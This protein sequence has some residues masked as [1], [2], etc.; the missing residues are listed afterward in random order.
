MKKRAFTLVEMLFGIFILALGV[1]SISALFAVG[2]TQQKRSAEAIE[3]PM[4]ARH[5]ADVLRGKLQ[6]EDFGA[7]QSRVG[8]GGSI[9][10]E[11]FDFGWSHPAFDLDT[12]EVWCFLPADTMTT[13]PYSQVK[14]GPTAPDIRF[15]QSERLWPQGAPNTN[16]EYAPRYAW[17]FCIRR[18]GGKVEAAIFV[19]RVHQQGAPVRNYYTSI[20]VPQ[21]FQLAQPWDAPHSGNPTGTIDIPG[22]DPGDPW[23]D[24]HATGTPILDQNGQVHHVLAGRFNGFD[25][26]ARLRRQPE[27]LPALPIYSA[28]QPA[29][30][31]MLADD[32][33]TDIW[34]VP[35]Q[36]PNGWLLTPVYV[37]IFSL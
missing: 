23:E 24:W 4:A 21:P 15:T 5:A 26:P 8:F 19:Y 3:G 11:E 7:H 20:P 34:F 18:T 13:L 35:R 28:G 6:A 32:I 2:I 17:D 14:Y 16:V 33:V 36:D 29:Q 12:G 31:G 25:G 27:V 1:I 9:V 22:T 10:W 30:N 37:G